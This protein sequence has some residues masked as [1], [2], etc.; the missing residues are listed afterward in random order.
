MKR[1]YVTTQ[2]SRYAS[3][4][5][6]ELVERIFK[7]TRLVKNCYDNIEKRPFKARLKKAALLFIPFLRTFHLSMLY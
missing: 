3:G 6:V 1:I 4:Q 7:L 2:R 5:T